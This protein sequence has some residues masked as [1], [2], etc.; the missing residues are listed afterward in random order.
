MGK[1]RDLF[2]KIGDTKGNFHL[3]MGMKEDINGKN[4]AETDK[5]RRGVKDTQ[6]TDMKCP[7]TW[8]TM[9]VWYGNSPTAK[10]PR[11]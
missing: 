11:V 2:K 8:M 1:I 6:I 9:M 5:L 7:I 10:H 4:L 3:R